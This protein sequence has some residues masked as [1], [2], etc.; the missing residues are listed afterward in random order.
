MSLVCSTDRRVIR[1]DAPTIRHLHV[2][3]VAPPSPTPPSDRRARSSVAVALVLDRSGSMTGEKFTLAREAV[4][5][6]LQRLAPSDQ[7]TL[8]AYDS[9]ITL[10]APIAPASTS[11]VQRLLAAL[12]GVEPRGSTD[13]AGGWFCGIDQLRTVAA[14]DAAVRR[15]LLLTDG[16]ANQGITDPARLAGCAESFRAAGL[17][18]STF[19]VGDDFDEHLL[20]RIAEEGGGNFCFIGE[21]AQIPT[22]LSGELDEVLDVALPQAELR[23]EGAALAGVAAV[24][25]RRV[26]TDG[27]TWTVPLGDLVAEQELSFVLRL[28]FAPGEPADRVRVAASV[29]S[30]GGPAV[31]VA[32]PLTWLRGGQAERRSQ[33]RDVAVDRATAHAYANRARREATA[34][35]RDGDLRAAHDVLAGTARR[36]AQYAG[37]DAELLALAE[38]L[39]REAA[40]FGEARMSARALKEQMFAAHVA[41]RSRDAMGRAR[42]RR[43]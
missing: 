10:L 4:R 2:Q 29:G 31:L 7:V 30:E 16:L 38:R 25:G 32:E 23:L 42:R 12:D 5:Q 1:I 15:C 39:R 18:T 26:R 28:E 14:S 3:L 41:E 40:E 19:G 17:T 20:R 33:P 43:P 9:E 35:N 6:C 21:A 13:L 8:A 22:M 24:D 36:I 11:H 34:F 27:R 37:E